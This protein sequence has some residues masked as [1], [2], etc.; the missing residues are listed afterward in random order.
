MPATHQEPRDSWVDSE[1]FHPVTE[2]QVTATF[3]L[4]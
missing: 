4:D 3:D 2:G 1:S